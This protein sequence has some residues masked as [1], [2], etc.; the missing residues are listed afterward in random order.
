MLSEC[1]LKRE[2]ALLAQ[3][4]SQCDTISTKEQ[5]SNAVGPTLMLQLQIEGVP[6]EAMVDTGS[7][8]TVVSRAVLHEVGKHLHQQGR[9]MPQL[10]APTA[11]L[12]GKDCGG[13]RRELDITAEVSLKI[14]ADGKAVTAPV[15]IQPD[16]EQPCL[17]GMNIAPA[18]GLKFLDANGLP[19]KA[20]TSL[21]QPS[22]EQTSAMVCLT[23]TS[24]LPGRKGRF[25]EAKVDPIIKLGTEILFEPNTESL[26]ALGL[27]AQESLLCVQRDGT[28]LI[29][30]QNFK[31]DTVDL[32]VGFKLGGVERLQT[33][34]LMQPSD[35]SL[36][37]PDEGRCSQV[38]TRRQAKL[39][40]DRKTKLKAMLN[41]PGENLTPEQFQQLEKKLMDNADVFA[42]EES[43]LGH[44]TV[45]KHSIDTGEHPPIKQCPRRTPFVHREKIA[46]LVNDMLKQQV[47]QPS[48]SAWA[49]PVVLVPKKDGN[50]RFCVDYRKVNAVTKKDVYPLPRVDDILD[51][52][53][54]AK[55]FSTLDL[56]SGYWQIEMDPATREKSAFT[57]HCGLFEF[58]RM[59]FGLC[60]SPA[61]FQRLMQ[62]IL[63]GLEW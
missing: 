24:T 40:E 51:T 15:F 8:S 10:R 30:L 56:A 13:E 39:Q 22:Q 16:S 46:Q 62:T 42:I 55:Y 12:Y 36:S 50:L 29:P 14:E 6:V 44:T 32:E 34:F 52:L 35:C 58:L 26:R 25:L 31:Q 63:A 17:L 61:T 28:V 54:K 45:V 60:N 20:L 4:G 3:N 47:V 21:S 49:S 18:L 27:S 5:T 57:T 11:R 48:S 53:G 41:L 38:T 23:Q 37:F 19:L 59:P 43:E 7:Q 2:E 1:R 9:E 33:K